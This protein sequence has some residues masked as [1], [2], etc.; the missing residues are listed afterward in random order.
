LQRYPIAFTIDLART[1]MVAAIDLK[2][3]VESIDVA[4]TRTGSPRVRG[5]LERLRQQGEDLIEPLY[6]LR[7][8][9]ASSGQPDKVVWVE[10]N[11]KV[12]S[13]ERP[14]MNLV[15]APLDIASF[16]RERS[17]IPGATTP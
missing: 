10:M 16:L 5:L 17:G 11:G 15:V 13:D 2:R 8:M 7:S 3:I 9:A 12:G 14:S 4:L 6:Q 1:A